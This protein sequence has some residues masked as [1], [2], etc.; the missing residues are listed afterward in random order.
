M[1]AETF[2]QP[3]P[4][5]SRICSWARVA[6]VA[7][8]YQ[9]ELAHLQPLTLADTSSRTAAWVMTHFDPG[10]KQSGI[11]KQHPAASPELR[12]LVKLGG[13]ERRF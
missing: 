8:P 2:Q 12:Q 11:F 6:A 3:S 13:L 9:T 5:E 7:L 10:E 4:W 1:Q